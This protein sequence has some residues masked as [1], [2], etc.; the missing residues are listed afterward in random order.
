V[1]NSYTPPAEHNNQGSVYYLNSLGVLDKQTICVHCIHVSR[2]EV[3][4][5]ADTGTKVCLCPGSNRYLNVGKAPVQLFLDHNILP[6]LGTDSQASNP[7]LSIWREM[8]LL[9][10]DNPDINSADILTMATLGGATAL[11]LT[12]DFG[13]FD[14]GKKSKFLAVQLV[15]AINTPDTLIEFLVTGN[16]GII[17]EW[18]Q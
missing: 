18:I 15:H 14:K 5:L 2:E 9:K 13:T 16:K 7:R 17:P 3:K 10:Q 8:R 4:I 12:R 11:G 1:E 6:A